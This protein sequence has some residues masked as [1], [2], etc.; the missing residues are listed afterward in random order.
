MSQC[1]IRI[2]ERMSESFDGYGCLI[3]IKGLPRGTEQQAGVIYY[4][5]CP[6]SSSFVAKVCLAGW[7]SF[8]VHGVILLYMECGVL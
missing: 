3:S 2:P 5:R 8:H 1:T 4:N 7:M 6:Y